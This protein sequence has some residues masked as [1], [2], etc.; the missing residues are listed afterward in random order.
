MFDQAVRASE[1]LKQAAQHARIVLRPA[2][3]GCE[4]CN[5]VQMI[6][7]PT[8]GR[9]EHCGSEQVVLGGLAEMRAIEGPWRNA[10]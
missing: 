6:A 5:R 10:A 1:A 4:T 3:S 9:C 2:R 7:A 8:L